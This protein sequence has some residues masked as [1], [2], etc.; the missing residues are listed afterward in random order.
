MLKKLFV[1]CAAALLMAACEQA[2]Q[3]SM[4]P[5]PPPAPKSFMVFF[6]WDSIKLSDQAMRTLTQAGQ[7]YKESGNVQVTVT[8][9]TDTSGSPQYNLALSL[10]RA[11]AVKD[12]LVRQGVPAASIRTIGAGEQ[13]LLIPTADGVR[14]PQNRRAEIVIP[15]MAAAP[16]DAAYCK[17]LAAKYRTIDRAN[18][19]AA[20]A[21]EAMH[22]CDV[23][24]YAA[25]IP[26]LEK[27]LTDGKVPLPP[28]S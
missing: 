2:P 7:A 5:P 16:N 20:R 24:N 14:E 4:Q 27:I 28:R 18:E 25:G 12:V 26:V 17:A 8:G 13:G 10:R 9:H 19:V 1:M 3:E 23:G 21:A 11:N 22:Q 6:D 15:Q